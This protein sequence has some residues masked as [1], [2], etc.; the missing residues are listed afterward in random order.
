MGVQFAA[1]FRERLFLEIA[2]H[3]NRMARTLS[4]GIIKAGGELV[5][6]TETNQVFAILNEEWV[7]DLQQAFDF[8]IWSK[9]EYEGTGPR[10]VVIRLV[11]SWATDVKQVNQFISR[12][13]MQGLKPRVEDQTIRASNEIASR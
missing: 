3:A 11:T 2:A 5:A 7:E 4:D 6:E 9:M 12:I 10:K 8:Y 13:M 1:L